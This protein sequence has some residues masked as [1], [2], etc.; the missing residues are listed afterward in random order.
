LKNLA[1]RR[2]RYVDLQVVCAISYPQFSGQDFLGQ[3]LRY[4]EVCLAITFERKKKWNFVN[5]DVMIMDVSK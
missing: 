4:K 1:P 3:P 5:F 2:P